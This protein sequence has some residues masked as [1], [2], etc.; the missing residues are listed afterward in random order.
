[1]IAAAID[2]YPAI[3]TSVYYWWNAEFI[4]LAHGRAPSVDK[5]DDYRHVV[6]ASYCDVFVSNDG[7]LL[8]SV[9]RLHPTLAPVAVGALLGST[10]S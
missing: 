8:R 10:S 2:H 1:M 7:Q 6:E 5:V 9:S 3:R 4:C